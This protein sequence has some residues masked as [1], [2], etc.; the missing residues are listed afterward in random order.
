M[1]SGVYCYFILIIGLNNYLHPF[2]Q[3]RFYL[4]PILPGPFL[5]G[6]FYQDRHYPLER[7]MTRSRHPRHTARGLHVAIEKW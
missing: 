7:Q 5:P 4:E 6:P 3:D 1:S 2:F